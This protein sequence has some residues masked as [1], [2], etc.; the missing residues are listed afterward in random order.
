[1]SLA[2]GLGIGLPFGPSG[3]AAPVGGPFPVNAVHFDGTNDYLTRGGELTGAVESDN[4]LLSIWFNL[5]GGD[6]VEMDI[7]RSTG[8]DV[9]FSREAGNKLAITLRQVGIGTSWVA[10]SDNDFTTISNAGWNHIL[11]AAQLDATPVAQIYLNDAVL[12]FTNV[13]GP[14]DR[15]ISFTGQTDWA[16]GA[17]PTGV[18]KLNGDLAEVWVDA[19]F[20]DI[21]VESNRRKFIDADGFP[22]DLGSDG[23][24]PTG[25]APIAFFSGS[26]DTWHTNDG[27]G[28]GYTENGALTDAD[29]SPSD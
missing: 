25:T 4:F 3:D 15:P 24:T 17:F 6:G 29:T 16:V 10:R 19:Q 8:S 9:N 26:T 2:I 23:S 21:S 28:G 1:M 20:L 27:S 12:A 5:T 22:V 14:V 18:V 7:F 13:T 11:I